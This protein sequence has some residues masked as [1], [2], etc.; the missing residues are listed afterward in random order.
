MT[1]PSSHDRFMKLLM[2]Q[3]KRLERFALTITRNRDDAKDIVGETVLKAFE[4]FDSLREEQAFLSFLFTIASR[5]AQSKKYRKSEYASEE[6]IEEL[7][8]NRTQPDVAMDIAMLYKAMEELPSDAREALIL[9][10]ITG[11]SHKEIQEIQ[12]GS[13]SAVKV[14]IFRAKKRLAELLGATEPL[15][16]D[17]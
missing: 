4:H 1:P 11:L 5:V 2:P 13:L 12:G 16:V 3:Y 17:A 6:Q 14:R 7:F 9:A 8:D 15:D 10:E